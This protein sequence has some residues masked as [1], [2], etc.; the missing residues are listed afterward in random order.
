MKYLTE[1][2]KILIIMALVVVGVGVVQAS[3]TGPTATAPANNT[4]APINVSTVTQEKGGIFGS[5]GFY[6]LGTGWFSTTTRA[7]PWPP[8]NLTLGINGA[9]GA[10]QYCDDNGANCK[11]MTELGGSPTGAVM[12]FD[13]ES[14]PSGWTAYTAANGRNIIGTGTSGTVGAVTHVRGNATTGVGGEEKHV[15][16]EAELATHQHVIPSTY[17]SYYGRYFIKASTTGANMYLMDG[18]YYSNATNMTGSGTA[19][20]VMDPYIALLYCKKS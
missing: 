18:N 8:A 15:Q 6:S 10:T 7:A 11:T 2:I 14:C 12:A 5:K 4:S 19:M 13:L 16:T 9:V 20:P 3:W 17:A 1:T